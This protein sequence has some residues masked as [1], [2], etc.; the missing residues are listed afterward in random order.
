MNPQQPAHRRLHVF[1]HDPSMA[2]QM[3]TAFVNEVV[4]RIP[5]ETLALGPVG[6]YVAVIDKGKSPAVL[7]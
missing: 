4:L 2:A 6:K 3:D 1:A 5:W 7:A